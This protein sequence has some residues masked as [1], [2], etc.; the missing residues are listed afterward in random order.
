[1]PDMYHACVAILVCLT[2]MRIPMSMSHV[3]PHVHP[4]SVYQ[5]QQ[6]EWRVQRHYQGRVKAVIL[7]WAGTVL[8]CGTYIDV[9]GS[10]LVRV[11]WL[12]G[13]TCRD[14]PH[15]VRTSCVYIHV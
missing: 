2:R 4:V 9:C 10:R 7:D 5:N 12:T 3:H 11:A 6:H 1:M 14:A 15:L 13:A 8:D